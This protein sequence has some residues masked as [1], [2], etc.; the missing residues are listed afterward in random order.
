MKFIDEAEIQVQAGH[1]GAGC[2]HFRRE[3]FVPF[4]GPDGGN[5]GNGGS[6]I[7]VA[8]RNRHTLLDFKFRPL[9]QAED[10]KAGDTSRK[11]GRAG[12][13]LIIKV[14]IGTQIVDPTT[15]EV[16]ADLDAEGRQFVLAR[17]GRGGKGNTFFKS[18]TNRAPEHAQPGEAGAEGVYKLSLK[19]VADVGLVGFPNAGKSTFIASVSA[20]RPK[21]ADYPFT[22]LTPNLGVVKIAGG[23]PIVIADIPGLIPGASEGKGL[24]IQFLKHVERT[25]VLLHLID[26]LQLADDGTLVTPQESFRAIRAE[27]EA[28]NL[29]LANRAAVVALTKAD[30]KPDEAIIADARE[31]FEQQGIECFVI[32]SVSHSGLDPLLHRLADLVHIEEPE[33]EADSA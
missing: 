2:K 12:E 31:W 10:G 4:G 23:K 30:T 29:D 17:G 5:G 24:G 18:A 1:G 25:R 15:E 33:V 8:D 32:S 14:P 21:I 13:D 9:W 6:V 20:A 3:K 26:P 27:L 7:T 22:T 11:D 28:F 19:L 16:L